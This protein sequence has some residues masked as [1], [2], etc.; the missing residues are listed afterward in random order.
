MG[1]DTF[2]LIVFDNQRLHTCLKVHFSAT[3]E[4]GIPHILYHTWQF[5]RSDM[6]MCIH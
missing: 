6:R 2:Y 4:N 5:I 1:F 3:F